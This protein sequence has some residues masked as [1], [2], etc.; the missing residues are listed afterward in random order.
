MI[1]KILYQACCCGVRGR[2]L[3][4]HTDVRRFESSGGTVF[5]N[6][7]TTIKKYL[8]VMKITVVRNL[9]YSVGSSKYFVVITLHSL[10]KNNS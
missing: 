9:H 5:F 10:E 3:A 6:L 7:L 8:Y 1:Y 2:A 4:S